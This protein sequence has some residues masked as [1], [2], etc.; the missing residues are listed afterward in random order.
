MLPDATKKEL[1][2]HK[3][4]RVEPLDRYM[5]QLR[6]NWREAYLAPVTH[7]DIWMQLRKNWRISWGK[8]EIR[9]SVIHDATKKELKEQLQGLDQYP[10]LYD[11]TKKELKGEDAGL[12]L[13]A[14]NWLV[15]I[16]LCLCITLLFLF[17]SV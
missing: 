12:F 13:S 14:V 17:F 7:I 1:K 6:K 16:L 10:F 8:K 9:A 5:M 15:I 3:L 4:C 11:A 2:A